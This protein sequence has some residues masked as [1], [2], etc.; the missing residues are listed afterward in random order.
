[1]TLFQLREQVAQ[2][3]FTEALTFSLC[4]RDDVSTKLRKDLKSDKI[5]AVHIANPKTL[6]FQVARTT[7]LPGLLKTVQANRKMPLPIK[8]F[9]ISDVVMTDATTDTGAKNERRLCAL[10]YTNASGAFEVVHGLLDRIM[11]V[12][13]VPVTEQGNDAGYYLV[14][15]DDDTF[16]P[17]RCAKIMAYGQ[18]VGRVGVLHPETGSKFELSLPIAALE[19]NVEAFL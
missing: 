16:F 5:P 12:L 4:S 14:G 13:D 17:G 8:L 9:E 10:N 19:I 2:A 11:Q 7:L 1:M 15:S 6:E 3:G 18:A